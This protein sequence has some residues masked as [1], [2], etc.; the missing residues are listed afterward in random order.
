MIDI[1]K[2]IRMVLGV[3]VT[4]FLCLNATGCSTFEGLRDYV[5]DNPLVA[6]IAT[7]QAVARYIAQGKTLEDEY[8]RAEQVEKRI[9]K[10]LL[11][12]D[13][14]ASA[15]SDRLLQVIDSSIEWE[16]LTPYDR[17]LVQ[18]IVSMV[19][20]E[21]ESASEPQISPETKIVISTLL[22]TAMSAARLYMVR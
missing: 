16:Q 19:A 21:L 9:Q 4:L 5:A 7:R 22:N 15:T 10:V 12:L 2:N 11:F 17:I 18:D 1:S 20:A 8:E 3:L 14:D 6:S 13:A